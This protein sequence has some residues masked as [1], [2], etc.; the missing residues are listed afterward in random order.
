M[1]IVQV[2]IH[3]LIKMLVNGK[4]RPLKDSFFF[5]SELL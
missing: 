2:R 1:S 3:V 4:G 5:F